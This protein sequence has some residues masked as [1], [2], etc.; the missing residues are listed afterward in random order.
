MPTQTPVSEPQIEWEFGTRKTQGRFFPNSVESDIAVHDSTVY[1]S[2]RDTDTLYAVDAYEGQRLWAY[3]ANSDITSGAVVSQDGE[4][5][6]FGTQSEGI[7][8]LT[9]DNGSR[10]WNFTR[11]RI[12]T[13]SVVPLQH[14]NLVIAASERG[15]IYALHAETGEL[16]WQFPERERDPIQGSFEQQ[17]VILDGFFY[18]GNED[19]TLYAIEVETV[20]N[21]RNRSLE[22]REAPYN[23]ELDPDD[24]EEEPIRSQIVSVGDHILFGNDAN[25]LYLLQNGRRVRCIYRAIDR[26]RGSIAADDEIVIFTDRTG[27]IIAIDPD[28]HD[29]GTCVE[30]EDF[31]PWK[32]LEHIWRANTH[33]EDGRD[34]E[35]GGGPIIHGQRVFA[36]DLHGILYTLD[37]DDGDDLFDN[38]RLWEGRCNN[39]N[40]SPAI[41]GDM[42]F[43]GTAYG[44]L[45][46]IRLP[47]D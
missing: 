30:D 35:V 23:E 22:P 45:I 31:L 4:L 28:S 39:C 17:G 16:E 24:Q 1:F 43:A 32:R 10:R 11:D 26:I 3:E 29:E 36:I 15:R 12:G 42:L 19:G 18:I 9:T 13:F 44:T 20:M 37:K 5:V 8:A 38:L 40:S 34:T 14:E 6:Y 33:R 2:A 47:P 7:Y 21:D 25:E 27:D 46:A 41:E